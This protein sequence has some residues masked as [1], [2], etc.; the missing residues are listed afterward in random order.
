MLVTFKLRRGPA[1]EWSADNPILSPGEP[2]YETD[3]GRF[4]VGDGIR[5]WSN[6]KYQVGLNDVPHQL[7]DQPI[8][9]TNVD[10]GGL[11]RVVLGGDRTLANP[12]NMNDG[13]R[14]VWEFVQDVVGSRIVTLD[15]AFKFGSD[16]S[17]L[18]LSTT[19]NK[20]DFMG[21]IYNEAENSWYV[22][23]VMKGY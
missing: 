21:A 5:N 11:F 13:D 19:P 15:T 16:I 7:V 23:A 22:I 9:L 14:V 18:V 17:S 6:L 3:T 10:L 1:S 8:L 4:K 2:G 20:R 12:T